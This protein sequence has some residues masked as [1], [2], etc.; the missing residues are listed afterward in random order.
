MNKLNEQQAIEAT[1]LWLEKIIID[2]NFCPFAKK[3]FVNNTVH[4]HVHSSQDLK[5]AIEDFAKQCLYLSNHAEI[6]TTLFICNQGFDD[7]EDYLDLLDIANEMVFS[8]GFEGIFQL[9]SFHPDYVFEGEDKN[10]ASNSTNRSPLPTIHIIREESMEKVLAVY[11]N[12]ENIP[13]NN[14][15]LA[16]EKGSD[17]FKNV[18]NEILSKV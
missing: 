6:E 17:F 3:E 9:A 18:M 13:T 5:R 10:D 12:P 15:A 1:K 2:L 4:Y 7:F 16:R 8:L 11:K 14:I